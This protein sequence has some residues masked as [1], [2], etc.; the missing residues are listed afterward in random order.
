MFIEGSATA[1]TVK[2][3]GLPNITGSVDNIGNR[4][5]YHFG[6]S[7]NDASFDGAFVKGSEATDTNE[8]Q[9]IGQLSKIRNF[10]FDASKSNSIYGNSTTVQ[11]PALT[12]QYIIKC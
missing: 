7:V 8:Y 3:A 2:E 5:G 1:G 9:T 10:T 4:S 12:M 11:P 6:I